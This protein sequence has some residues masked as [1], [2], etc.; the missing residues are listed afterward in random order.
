MN[1]RYSI[2]IPSCIRLTDIEGIV[3]L[4][5]L[6][7][8]WHWVEM[9]M[10]AASKVILAERSNVD[11][12]KAWITNWLWN[13]RLSHTVIMVIS[14]VDLDCGHIRV[15]YHLSPSSSER[16]L[17]ILNTSF[18]KEHVIQTGGLNILSIVSHLQFAN[19]TFI[20]RIVCCSELSCQPLTLPDTHTHYTTV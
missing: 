7:I 6:C 11:C 8:I 5:L 17:I 9:L 12:G 13:M 10:A 19:C 1:L 20:H 18:M 15:R 16:H 2:H 3:S 4:F 14:F